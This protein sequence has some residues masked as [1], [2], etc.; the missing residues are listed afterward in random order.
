MER[1]SFPFYLDSH[2]SKKVKI[3]PKMKNLIGD[4]NQG[5]N[6]GSQIRIRAQLLPLRIRC[7]I[8]TK[9]IGRLQNLPH[10][11]ESPK[12]KWINGSHVFQ[13]SCSEKLN[14]LFNFM[15]I[16]N[17]TPNTQLQFSYFRCLFLTKLPAPQLQFSYFSESQRNIITM[18][19]DV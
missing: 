9:S 15:F 3:A 12:S 14:S 5:T 7:E 19:V 2:K 6:L 11:N 16:S 4:K 17:Q 13:V 1:V 18:V 8:E 10:Q